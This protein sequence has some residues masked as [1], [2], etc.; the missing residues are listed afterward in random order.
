MRESI[1][2]IIEV[3]YETVT[4]GFQAGEALQAVASARQNSQDAAPA[5]SNGNGLGTLAGV[6]IGSHMGYAAG[7]G[8]ICALGAISPA[9][10]P[11]AILGFVLLKD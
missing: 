6:F 10:V 2:Q 4:P 3:D 1:P 11:A 7:L 8:V 9:L 5:I